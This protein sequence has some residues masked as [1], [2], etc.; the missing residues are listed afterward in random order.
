MFSFTN[1]NV[2]VN[3]LRSSYA[4]YLHQNRMIVKEKDELAKKMRT[5]RRYLDLNYIKILPNTS[6]PTTAATVAATIEPNKEN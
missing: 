6:T 4:S 5:S 3:S 1:K 2:G